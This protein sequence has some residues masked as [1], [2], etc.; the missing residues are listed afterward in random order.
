MTH[1]TLPAIITPVD[2]RHA[3]NHKPIAAYRGKFGSLLGCNLPHVAV[4][5]KLQRCLLGRAPL[6]LSL[7]DC[8]DPVEVWPSASGSPRRLRRQSAI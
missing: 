1:V 4:E 3:K 6:Q 7:T 2:A 5:A 8:L